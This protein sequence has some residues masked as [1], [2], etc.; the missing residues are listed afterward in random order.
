MAEWPKADDV[1]NAIVKA[2]SAAVVADADEDLEDEDLDTE[3]QESEDEAK[4][5]DEQNAGE[6]ENKRTD[7]QQEDQ[8]D[9]ET[10]K[11]PKEKKGPKGDGG[12]AA[13]KAIEKRDTRA[14]IAALPDDMREAFGREL[15]RGMQKTLDER[16]KF[17]EKRVAAKVNGLRT[18]FERELEEIMTNGLD[19]ETAKTV[20]D[21]RKLKRLER[22]D[23][24]RRQEAQLREAVD[25]A[26]T[27]WWSIAV[28]EGGLPSDP[29]DPV[30]R[31]L[32]E[33]SF[34]Q[35]TFEKALDTLR[36]D[37]RAM[38]SD[39]RLAKARSGRARKPADQRRSADDIEAL[40][41]ERAEKLVDKRL[42]ELGILTA[43]KG[44]PGGSAGGTTQKPKS[45]AEA[46][47][48][49]IARLRAGRT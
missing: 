18:D 19:E 44:K 20:K 25:N 16:D 12:D 42:R 47:Q 14:L 31:E 37:I 29:D 17:W 4:A 5:D 28:S 3:D 11:Q 21:Q 41:K 22:D 6:D 26:V 35:P 15:Y 48:M 33:R 7:E 36:A 38:R 27:E 9:D 32:W 24:Q 1:A 45:M 40:A 13:R 49:A 46:S 34:R 10:K 8:Q 43:D 39:G 30:V 23:S 2:G